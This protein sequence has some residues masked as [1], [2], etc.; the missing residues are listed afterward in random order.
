M[1]AV[2]K[3]QELCEIRVSMNIHAVPLSLMVE[4]KRH[5]VSA[6]YERWRETSEGQGRSTT[7]DYFKI[8]TNKG[9]ICD[10]CY[11][12]EDKRWY[13]SKIYSS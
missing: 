5:H 7:K 13:M 3:I 8:K 12:R 6:I 4:S 1:P 2:N 11:Y 9:L 10:I